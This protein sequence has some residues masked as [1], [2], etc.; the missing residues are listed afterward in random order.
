MNGRIK[1]KDKKEIV[2]FG[3]DPVEAAV[4]RYMAEE[5]SKEYEPADVHIPYVKI[6]AV[7]YPPEENPSAGDKALV[8]GDFWLEN[9]NIRGDTLECFSNGNYSG[10]MH[11]NHNNEV[12][13]FECV[14]SCDEFEDSARK[15]FGDHYDAFMEVY[16]NGEGLEERRRET[17]SEY[18]RRNGL[19]VTKF[20]DENWDPVELD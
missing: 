13:E 12:T 4:C 15:I 20:Q 14:G 6:A 18:V 11:V 17:V 1:M 8:Y 2:C 19:K 5:L 7:E 16:T 3:S 10:A 9:Y